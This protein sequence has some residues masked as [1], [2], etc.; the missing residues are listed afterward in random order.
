[1]KKSELLK[2]LAKSA[3]VSQ[4]QADAVLS[5]FTTVLTSD[6]LIKGES[7]VIPGLGTFKQHKSTARVGRHPQTGAPINLP[8]STSLKFHMSSTLK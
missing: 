3:N 2:A 1:M 5:A 8:E 7:L 6:V 4:V